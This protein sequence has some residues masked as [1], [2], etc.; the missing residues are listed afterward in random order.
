MHIV[1]DVSS[2]DPAKFSEPLRERG[3]ELS[4]LTIIL[5]IEGQQNAD[6]PYPCGLLRPQVKRRHND[7]GTG[8]RDECAPSHDLPLGSGEAS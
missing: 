8:Q 1:L 5:I 6:A 4:H 3:P 7:R 2:F